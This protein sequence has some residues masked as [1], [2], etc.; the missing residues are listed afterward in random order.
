LKYLK[1]ALNFNQYPIGDPVLKCFVSWSGGKDS[2]LSC[3]KAKDVEILY[4]LNMVTIDAKRSMTHGINSEILHAQS[5]CMDIPIIQKRTTWNTYEQNFNDILNELKKKGVGAGIF[6][7][8]DLQEHR[9]WIK[10][11]AAM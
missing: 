10:E 9:N 1:R 2:C 3:Y 8:I 6:G 7:D 11:F 5:E 4:L